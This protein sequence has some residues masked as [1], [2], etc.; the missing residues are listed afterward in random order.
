M[1]ISS[2]VRVLYNDQ[3]S[4]LSEDFLFGFY[5]FENAWKLPTM[6]IF[7]WKKVKSKH[8]YCPAV[9]GPSFSAKLV[10]DAKVKNSACWNALNVVFCCNWHA[11]EIN[12][13]CKWVF[14]N[15]KIYTQCKFKGT[16]P[17]RWKC[18]C[19]HKVK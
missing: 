17:G 9:I 6:I 11:L 2:F 14:W 1:Q 5:F 16:G 3:S 4:R 8:G 19:S 15:T 13:K 18:A 7:Q 10:L 12:F